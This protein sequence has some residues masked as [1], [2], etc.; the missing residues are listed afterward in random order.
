MKMFSYMWRSIRRRK[1]VNFITMGISILLVILLNIY[2]LTIGSYRKQ[3]KELAESIPVYCQITNKNG[4]RGNGLFI[5]ESVV[6]GL[7]NS[8]RITNASYL[9]WM[10]AGEGEFRATQAAGNLN[11][12]VA[13]ANRVEA[14]PGLTEDKIQMEGKTPEAFFSGDRPECIVSREVMERRG[15]KTGDR[16]LLNLYYYSGD[17]VTMKLYL[18]P[19]E[20]TEIEIAGSMESLQG[21]TSAN[22]ADVIL[23]L[24]TIRTI[25]HRNDVPFFADTVTFYVKDPLE[26]NEFKEEMKNLNLGERSPEGMD[27]YVGYTLTVRDSS[28]VTKA[29]DLQHSIELMRSFL[30]VVCIMVFLIGYVVSDLLGSS[31]IEE[32]VLLRLQGVKEM[33]ASL[34]FLTEQMLLVFAGLLLGNVVIVLFFGNSHGL[35]GGSAVLLAA[36]LTGAAVACQ[37]MGAGNVMQ[38]FTMQQ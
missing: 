3:L 14:V 10:M 22:A 15:W 16:I 38:S 28:F 25:C 37:R 33:Q 24:D 21:T 19:L 1:I 29:G 9:A 2:F 7:R 12:F 27:S 17:S 18:Y 26:L 23:P 32:Y 31:R 30:P 36:Y 8:D 35:A 11:L 4:S 6:E 34:L 5:S 13:G 20:L